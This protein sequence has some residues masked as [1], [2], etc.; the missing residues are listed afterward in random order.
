MRN[1]RIIVL[2]AGQ[3]SRLRPLTDSV[4]KCMVPLHGMPL[5]YWHLNT[6]RG[7]DFK[8]IIVV[9]GYQI[10]QI[11]FP[12]ITLLENKDFATTNMVATL[13]TARDWFEDGF[14]VAYGDILYNQD[15]LSALLGSPH[16][17]S[18]AVDR[19]WHSYWERRVENILDDAE[20]L[21]IDQQGRIISIGQKAKTESEIKGQYIG[22]V[23]FDEEGVEALEGLVRRELA[24]NAKGTRIIHHTRPFNGL[25][26]TDVLQ[27]LA[28]G[29]VEVWPAWI[30]GGWLEVDTPAD[31]RLA[32]TIT[33]ANGNALLVQR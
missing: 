31:L 13:W 25:Y 10:D 17:I 5:L 3:G 26:M 15:V 16:D 4:P 29:G 23:A 33:C 1:D 27:A 19:Q 12:G 7:M 14:V 8:D 24:A 21:K 20:S 28:D 9:G 32:E 22:L 11:D 6:I 18:V 2:A 30:D